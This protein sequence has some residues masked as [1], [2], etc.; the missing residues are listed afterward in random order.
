M[1]NIASSFFSVNHEVLPCLVTLN[2]YVYS[3]NHL[4][5]FFIDSFLT[6]ICAKI[7]MQLEIFVTILNP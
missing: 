4:L 7:I 1:D 6:D 3:I 5:Y 2:T